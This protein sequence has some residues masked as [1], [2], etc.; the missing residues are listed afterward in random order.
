M[1]NLNSDA[2]PA[3][4]LPFRFQDLP[5]ELQDKMYEK[6]HENVQLKAVARPAL[7]GPNNN[8]HQ[9]P[10]TFEG[11]PSLSIELVNRKVSN[12]SRKVRDKVWPRTM[13]I[14][15]SLVDEEELMTLGTSSYAWLHKNIERM[16]VSPGAASAS[17]WVDLSKAFINLRY[18]KFRKHACHSWSGADST[19]TV[20]TL[21]RN[22]SSSFVL[23][24]THAA[25]FEDAMLRELAVELK[26]KFGS[27]FEVIVE[28]GGSWVSI[29][30]E[31]VAETVS[32][33][34][35]MRDMPTTYANQC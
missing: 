1:A 15:G 20:Q 14:G 34:R 24:A 18:F 11:L 17:T 6:H 22:A 10:L 2:K 13:E 12:D 25:Y 31:K 3:T 27:E 26:R 21:V 9:R 16:E 19:T 35:N 29:G 33:H 23:A 30:G 32:E 8:I 7:I 28:A 4:S 5:Q